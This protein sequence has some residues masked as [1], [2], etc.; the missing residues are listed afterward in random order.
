MVGKWSA[1]GRFAVLSHGAVLLLGSVVTP[2]TGDAK[3]PSFVDSKTRPGD[4]V[5]A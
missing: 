5:N 3:L 1:S 2:A 4:I